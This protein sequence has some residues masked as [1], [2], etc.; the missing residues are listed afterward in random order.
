VIALVDYGAGN[1]TSVVKALHHLGADVCIARDPS[2][3]ES[4][5]GVIVPG[6]GHFSATAVL[7]GTWTRA[8]HSAIDRGRPLLGICVGMQWLFE[9]S[10]E[11]PGVAGLGVI[12]GVCDRLPASSATDET[13]SPL[14]QG[15]GAS[16]SAS[17]AH[18]FGP[19]FRNRVVKV[20]HV[21]W[22]ALSIVRRSPL[23][24]GIA[25]GDQVYFTHSFAAPLT[26]ETVMCTEHGVR[27]ASAVDLGRVAGVQFH[28]E[29]SGD[30]GLR[31]LSNF[32]TRVAAS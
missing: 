13:V 7:D 28:P 26:G 15:F 12:R 32:L 21:G 4:A 16:D 31:V 20:P 1:L 25:D 23:A 30:V 10:T 2:T 6:V 17:V 18:R 8:I 27:F 11:A 24:D 5:D 22:N 3:V 29:K 19:A 9:G 14:A